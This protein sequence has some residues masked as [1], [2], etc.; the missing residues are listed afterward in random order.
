MMRLTA[1]PGS[2]TF[3]PRNPERFISHV[4]SVTNLEM[5]LLGHNFMPFARPKTAKTQGER[6]A[7]STPLPKQTS[8]RDG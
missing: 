8:L 1:V 6:V 5:P 4:I 2:I 3:R 7:R